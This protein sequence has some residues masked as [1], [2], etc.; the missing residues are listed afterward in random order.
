MYIY[1]DVYT[2]AVQNDSANNSKTE[3]MTDT[4]IEIETEAV[5]NIQVIFYL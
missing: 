1:F 5:S 3:L 4:E 2:A